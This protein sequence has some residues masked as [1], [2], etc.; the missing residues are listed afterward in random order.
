MITLTNKQPVRLATWKQY[1]TVG[2]VT[3]EDAA[4]AQ[5]NG[6]DVAYAVNAGTMITDSKDYYKREKAVFASAVVIAQDQVV[7]IDGLEYRVHVNRGNEHE[8]RN[9]DPI[10]FIPVA[11]GRRPVM[12]TQAEM[13]VLEQMLS[14]DTRIGSSMDGQVLRSARRAIT[15]AMEA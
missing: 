13:I 7:M 4:R 1:A 14:N 12:L 8:C 9:A 15:N 11:T 2:Y 10:R 5:R 3:G 6:H